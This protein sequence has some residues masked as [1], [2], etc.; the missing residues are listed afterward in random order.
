MSRRN[1][2]HHQSVWR[3]TIF[4]LMVVPPAFISSFCLPLPFLFESWFLIVVWFIRFLEATTPDIQSYK[5]SNRLSNR[6]QRGVWRPLAPFAHQK[7]GGPFFG[8]EEEKAAESVRFNVASEGLLLYL[9]MS[10]LPIQFKE[11]V[12][13][14]LRCPELVFMFLSRYH[15]SANKIINSLA[16]CVGC[17]PRSHRLRHTDHGIWEIY[18]CARRHHQRQNRYN[19]RLAKPFQ[20]VK[21]PNCCRCSS[22][23]SLPKYFGT[24]RWV[25]G[26]FLCSLCS[27]PWPACSDAQQL[28]IYDLT[29]KAKLNDCTTAEPI[30]FWK[31]ISDSKLALVSATSVYHWSMN[32]ELC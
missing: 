16:H 9:T 7:R 21:A 4:S 13:V 3:H 12:Q 29:K 25:E 28:Q 15:P 20:R 17:K 10:E 27:F 19:C 24:Q 32:G 23:E 30:E 18:L 22:H 26:T 1:T 11:I 8:T 31:W 14:S 5:L 2:T 6:K